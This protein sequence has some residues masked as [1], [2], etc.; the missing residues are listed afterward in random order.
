[1]TSNR[2][3]SDRFDCRSLRALAITQTRAL[4]VQAGSTCLGSTP[5]LPRNP[6]STLGGGGRSDAF[7]G[8]LA[9]AMGREY[10]SFG[11]LETGQQLTTG[12]AAAGRT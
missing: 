7:G 10:I 8:R 11:G 3:P 5:R 12:R 6:S 1:M 2:N 4:L 9:E